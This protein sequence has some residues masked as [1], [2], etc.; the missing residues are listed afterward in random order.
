M[1]VYR[2]LE[3]VIEKQEK[4]KVFAALVGEDRDYQLKPVTGKIYQLSI[5]IRFGSVTIL[6]QMC[7]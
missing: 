5:V 1:T 7:C 3:P 4:A 6:A 2:I